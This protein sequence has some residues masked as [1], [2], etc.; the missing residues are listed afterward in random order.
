[1]TPNI[2]FILVSGILVAIASGLVGTFLVL[3]KM[4]LM[5]DALSHIALPGIALGLLFHIQPLWGGFLFLFIGILLIWG[6]E[7]KTRLAIESITGVLFTTALA[8]GALMIPEH[9]LLEAFFGNVEKLSI[10]QLGLQGIIAIFVIILTLRFL[11]PLLLMG[12]APDL[13]AAE[14]LSRLKMEL[15]LLVL[16]ALTITIGIGFVGVLLMSALTIIPAVTARNLASSFKEFIIWSVVLST[17][18]LTIGLLF[19][20]FFLIPPGIATVFVS[21]LLFSISLFSSKK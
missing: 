6:I 4:T 7:H 5:S 20:Y 9:D 3:R 21:A 17:T 13:A 12:V 11:K 16:I 8:A 19:H 2:I 18:S 15:L 10:T 1:M 14:K